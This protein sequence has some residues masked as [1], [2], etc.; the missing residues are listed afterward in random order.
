M[1][2]LTNGYK[3]IVIKFC[4]EIKFVD[5]NRRKFD[6]HSEEIKIIW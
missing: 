2:I 6:E 4:F 5:A 3:Q 1:K